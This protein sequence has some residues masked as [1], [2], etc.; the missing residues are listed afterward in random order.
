[1]QAIEK[2]K[3]FFF[4]FL[5]SL[6]FICAAAD[7]ITGSSMA[8]NKVITPWKWEFLSRII[9]LY[10]PLY[11]VNNIF[12]PIYTVKIVFKFL[13]Y[14][15]AQIFSIRSPLEGNNIIHLRALTVTVLFLLEST[16]AYNSWT[17]T[18]LPSIYSFLI[19]MQSIVRHRKVFSQWLN[20]SLEIFNKPDIR[21][22]NAPPF[23][24]SR[25]WTKTPDSFM[26]F[27]LRTVWSLQI[28]ACCTA[29]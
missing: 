29:N 17:F 14:T 11:Y 6:R 26:I 8:Y 1:M 15:L 10:Y 23:F 22:M 13:L 4:V 27:L 3:S 28:T 12:T 5:W 16:E 2:K 19:H 25:S 7:H 9:K 18:S 24:G 21:N 20:L